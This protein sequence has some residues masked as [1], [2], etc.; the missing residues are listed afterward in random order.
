MLFR[1]SSK[2]TLSLKELAQLAYDIRID[3]IQAL[4]GAKSG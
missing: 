4:T 2:P 1:S 3:I